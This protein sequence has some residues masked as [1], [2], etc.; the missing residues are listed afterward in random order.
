M[1]K[2]EKMENKSVSLGVVCHFIL[3]RCILKLL[4]STCF[5]RLP[6]QCHCPLKVHMYKLISMLLD[7]S[8][9]L[10]CFLALLDNYPNF[11]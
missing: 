10:T 1:L 5:W 11:T 3:S 9:Y 4:L 8:F 6:F 7:I 2:E